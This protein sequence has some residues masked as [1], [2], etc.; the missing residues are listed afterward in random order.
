K[1][2]VARMAKDGPTEQELVEAK[3][4]LVGS[5][6]INNLDSSSAVAST[7]IG[8]QDEHL[9]RDYIDKRADLINAV[10]LDQV[11]AAARKLLETD[12]AILIIGPP[13]S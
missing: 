3:K 2:E 13:Q 1:D 10:T 5:Y 7:L 12:P 4:Y 6:A 9:G 11:K 8:L